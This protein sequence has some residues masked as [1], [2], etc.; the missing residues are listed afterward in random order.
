MSTPKDDQTPLFDW[1]APQVVASIP[2]K[3]RVP[4]LVGSGSTFVFLFIIILCATLN[5]GSSLNKTV[6]GCVPKKLKMGGGMVS[7]PCE[8][9][10]DGRGTWTVFQRRGQFGNPERYFSDKP[11]DEYQAGFGDVNG[12]FWLGLDNIADITSK[13]TWQLR[14]DLNDWDGKSYWSVYKSF[15]LE[16]G[17]LYRLRLSGFNSNASTAGDSM[18]HDSHDSNGMAFST[19]DRDNDNCSGIDCA[20]SYMGAWWYNCCQKA[21]LNGINYKSQQNNEDAKG[22]Y[23]KYGNIRGHGYKTWKSVQM[24]IRKILD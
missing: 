14:V 16:S 11:W 9:D 1:K 6:S 2:T 12:E 19:K 10:P 20:R 3:W 4:L 5:R 13:G 15:K 24:K 22:I 17:P 7:V 23:W 8:F 18:T 21:N